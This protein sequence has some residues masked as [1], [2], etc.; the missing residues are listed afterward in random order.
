M[1]ATTAGAELCIGWNKLDWKIGSVEGSDS[2]WAPEI[3]AFYVVDD[4]FD[5]RLSAKFASG[6]D[7]DQGIDTEGSFFRLN[8]GARYWIDLNAFVTPYVGASLGY[9]NLDM[10]A[11][12]RSVSVDS[13]IGF[14]VQ[15][16][17]AF[18]LSDGF[19]LT[20][21]LTYDRLLMDA[22]ATVD[23]ESVDASISALGVDAG[24]VLL[25]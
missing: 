16:G 7:Q 1:P 8:L 10:D 23:G 15:T 11:A 13:G 17:C 6:E 24:V 20:L 4:S 18:G 9:Y 12:D 25:F 22:D 3:A 14:N 2:V 21:G 5:V 19:L